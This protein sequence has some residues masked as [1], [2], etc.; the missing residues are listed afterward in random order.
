MS[1]VFIALS[2]KVLQF[3]YVQFCKGCPPKYFSF[4]LYYFFQKS[5]MCK[6][7]WKCR[8]IEKPTS[9]MHSQETLKFQYNYVAW[10]FAADTQESD[11]SAPSPL[12]LTMTNTSSAF[13]NHCSPDNWV[14]V[15]VSG[16]NIS[17]WVFTLILRYLMS[18]LMGPGTSWPQPEWSPYQLGRCMVHLFHK[19][20]HWIKYTISS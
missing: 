9:M 4:C 19:T 2:D 18:G 13:G 16:R 12:E 1:I 15:M 11:V 10:C 6:K 17:L 7:K 20:L 14:G 5:I 3:P 8:V